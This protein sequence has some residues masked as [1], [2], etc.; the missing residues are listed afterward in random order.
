MQGHLQKRLGKLEESKR[1]VPNLRVCIL[2]FHM[3]DRVHPSLSWFNI[4]EVK[5]TSIL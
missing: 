3:P 4:K 5:S 1:I 2:T